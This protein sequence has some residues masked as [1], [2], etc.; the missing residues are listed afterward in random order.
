MPLGCA[1]LGVILCGC[2]TAPREG[3][4]DPPWDPIR[5]LHEKWPPHPEILEIAD[6]SFRT[7]KP[8][9]IQGSGYVVRSLEALLWAF[10]DAVQLPRSRAPSREPRRRRRHHRLPCAVSSPAASRANRESP[11]RGVRTLRAKTRSCR[12]W[13]DSSSSSRDRAAEDS[14]RTCELVPS[15]IPIGFLLIGAYKLITAALSVALG[16]GLFRLFQADVRTT[17]EPLVRGLRLD[18]E[19]AFIHSVISRLAGLNPR[20]AALD[21]GWNARCTRCFTWSRES[22][23]SEED[24][25]EGS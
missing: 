14:G 15:R 24:G 7:R 5:R 6:G 18:P 17:L 2:C 1:Y 13:S 20:S 23:S 10:H 9:V 12:S 25:G 21:R 3:V 16:F 22:A 8:P 4:L 19:N 11:S